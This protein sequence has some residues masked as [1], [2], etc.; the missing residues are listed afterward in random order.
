MKSKMLP[1][2]ASMLAVWTVLLVW[3][4][5]APH[6]GGLGLLVFLLLLAWPISM[7]GAESVFCRRHAFRSEYLAGRSWLYRLM[8]MEPLVLAV[9]AGKGLVLAALLMTVALSLNLRGWAVWLL[10]VLIL[11]MLMPRLPG[12]LADAVKRTYLFALAR[13][14]AI[15]LSTLLLWLE[16]VSVLLLRGGDDYRGL[17]WQEALAYSM[18]DGRLAA[19]GLVDAMVRSY[20]GM[21]GLA[22]WSLSVLADGADLAM[23][24]EALLALGAVALL[25]LLVA[26]AYSRAL[27]GALARPLAIW[28]PRPRR[29]AGGDVLEAWWL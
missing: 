10:D 29:R 17:S 16:S 15:W 4:L 7:A 13:R 9:E 19:D 14:W 21:Q 25:W 20:A 26:L 1:R 23:R 18:P 11:A 27:I 24:L 28:R 2:M 12:L 22:G 3:Q 5:S 8:G 6:L